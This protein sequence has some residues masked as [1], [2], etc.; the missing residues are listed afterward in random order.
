MG[1]RT[2]SRV[3]RFV[4]I[5]CFRDAADKLDACLRSLAAQQYQNFTVCMVDDASTD[6]SGLIASTWA[7]AQGWDLLTRTERQGAVRNQW[8]AIHQTCTSPDD[9]V[10]WVDGD[11]RLARPDT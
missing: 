5:C 2:D 8:D 9:V 7:N 10:V 3:R 1:G 4:V 6:D 11:D